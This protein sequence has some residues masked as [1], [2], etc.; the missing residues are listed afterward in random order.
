MRTRAAWLQGS[1]PSPLPVQT[2]LPSPPHASLPRKCSGLWVA[3]EHCGPCKEETETG[4]LLG[5]TTFL[6]CTSC[7]SQWKTLEPGEVRG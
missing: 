4:H 7:T 5:P 1:H 3:G 6:S 2:S